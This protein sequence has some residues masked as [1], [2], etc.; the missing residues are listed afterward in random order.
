MNKYLYIWVISFVCSL[1]AP[2]IPV[3]CVNEKLFIGQMHN[4]SLQVNKKHW[5]EYHALCDQER[6]FEKEMEKVCNQAAQ[7]NQKSLD[8]C[9]AYKEHLRIIRDQKELILARIYTKAA[10]SQEL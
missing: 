8:S 10:Q 7:G 3:L 5:Q 2:P 4:E 1:Y 6:L 9:G